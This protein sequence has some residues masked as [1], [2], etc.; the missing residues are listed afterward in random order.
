MP[1]VESNVV[2]AVYVSFNPPRMTRA[3]WRYNFVVRPTWIAPVGDR[4]GTW[5]LGRDIERRIAGFAAG[6][7]DEIVIVAAGGPRRPRWMTTIRRC[8][9]P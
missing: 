2:V 6:C 3:V 7:R 5:M 9:P 4:I 1:V 8:L